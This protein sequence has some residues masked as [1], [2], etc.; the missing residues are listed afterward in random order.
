MVVHANHPSEIDASVEQALGR[1]VDTGIPVL[2][3]SVLLRGVNDDIESLAELSRRL[4]NLRVVPYY[5]H[6]LDRVQG[7][8]HFEVP[9]ERGLQLIAELRTRLPGYAAPRYVQE[10]A[11]EPG[12]RVLA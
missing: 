7:A 10:I 5:L 12:K 6:Q 1:L 3:Q 4:V 2:N 9:V 8:A 11:G